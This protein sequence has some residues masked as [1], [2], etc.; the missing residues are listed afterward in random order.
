M[1]EAP[2]LPGGEASFV[3]LAG[4]RWLLEHGEEGFDPVRLIDAVRIAAPYR[5]LAVRRSATLWAVGA[6]RIEI[7]ELDRDP[8]GDRI[9]LIREGGEM[10]AIIDGRPTLARVPELERLAVSRFTEYVVE[11]TRLQGRLWEIS[12]SPL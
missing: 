9:E 11:A 4:D 3:L 12:I 6:R 1:A 8:G 2:E 7:A 10:A 5:A